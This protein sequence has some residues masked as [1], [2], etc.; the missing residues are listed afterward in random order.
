M[1]LLRHGESHFNL[2]F[3]KTRIDP[4]IV[5]PGLTDEG[6]RQAAAAGRALAGAGIRRVLVSPYRRTLETAAELLQTLESEV[7]VVVE[8][9]VRERAF[10]VCDVGSPRS[11]LEQGWPHLDFGGLPERWWPDG[12]EPESEMLLRCRSFR[13]RIAARED[14][15]ETLVVSHWA[16]IRGLT[17]EAIA[18]GTHLRFDPAGSGASSA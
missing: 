2:H 13:E 5:D 11:A 14:W 4:G 10:F 16:F 15:R 18:N 8:P 17:G 6:R 3:N 1:I 7:E 9:L 12:E